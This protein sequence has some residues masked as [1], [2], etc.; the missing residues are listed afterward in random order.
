MIR[1]IIIL[2]YGIIT[3]IIS[4]IYKGTTLSSEILLMMILSILFV[5]Y[6]LIFIEVMKPKSKF[7]KFL[8]KRLV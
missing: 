5:Y 8:T 4:V 3:V 1:D 6:S 7:A 2:I